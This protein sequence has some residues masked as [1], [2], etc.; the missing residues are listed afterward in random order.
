MDAKKY[1]EGFDWPV[2]QAFSE[3]L[4]KCKFEQGDVLYSNR[5]AYELAWGEAKRK[6][7]YSIQIISP[8]RSLG[9]SNSDGADGIFLSNWGSPV[10]FELTSYQDKKKERKKT[11]QGNLYMTLLHGN[12]SIVDQE[13]VHEPPFTVSEINRRLPDIS[14]EKTRESQFLLAFDAT[15]EILRVKRAKIEKALAELS[16]I[17][18]HPVQSVPALSEFTILPTISIIVFDVDLNLP[19]TEAKI[20]EAV[21]VPVKNKKTDRERFRLRDHGLLR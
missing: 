14:F 7:E 6:L 10:E 15:S 17:H 5:C 18:E 16:S 11:S 9:S 12:L 2:P 1:F 13:E 8:P 4:A 21:Y 19:E 20:K 3:A